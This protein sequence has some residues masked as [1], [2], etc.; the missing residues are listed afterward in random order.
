MK[1]FWMICV[2]VLVVLSSGRNTFSQKSETDDYPY[3]WKLYR[4][5]H[6]H[7]ELSF[8][9]K[10]TA[11]RMM[12][13]L[14]AVGF[15]VTGNVGGHG[16]VGV[17]RNGKGP[18]IML[19]TDLDALPVVEQTGLAYAS[20][21]KVKDDDGNEV[22]AMHACGHDIHMTV[23]VGTARTMA[24]NRNRWSGT[25]VMVGQPAEEKGAGARE[26]LADGLFKR[27]PRPDKAVALH[28]A[29]ALPAG[30]IGVTEGFA[31]ANVDS[32]DVVV[33]GVG[34][35]G[36]YPHTTKDPVVVA[37]EIIVALQT[38]VSREISPLEPAVVT[39]GSIHGGTKHNIISNKVKMQ[40]TCRSYTDEVRAKI[41]AGIKRI[42]RGV[43]VAMGLPEDMMP[44]VTVLQ[45][46][47]PATYND[48]ALTKQVAR[49]CRSVVGESKV[50]AK[51]PVMGGED[52]S[53]Y[54]RVSPRIPI[55]MYWLGVVDPAVWKKSQDE[56][57]TLPS[58]HSPFFKPLP[59]PTIRAGVKCMSAIA[60]DLLKKK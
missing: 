36:A 58:L 29:A 24:R 42:A 17:L 54:G 26:M 46:F 11:E 31:L 53:R 4:H 35:H 47:T 44:E 30:H 18:T 7:P 39:V 16:I 1:I 33:H 19:R 13:E 60:L 20:T 21:V 5:L 15:T 55:C 10:S 56:G 40:L 45:E 28:C 6:T 12:K 38:L 3:L 34:G 23:F 49:V 59:E 9:E 48:P 27:F 52:F 57:T 22:G 8:H 50:T 37:A 32:V 51:K 25:L 2:G 43:A 14:R 41:I